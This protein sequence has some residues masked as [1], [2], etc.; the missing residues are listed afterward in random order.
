MVLA[1]LDDFC[2]KSIISSMLKFLG[3]SLIKS[4]QPWLSSLFLPSNPKPI[5]NEHA[6]LTPF[7][8]WVP[9]SAF[10]ALFCT[11]GGWSW[12]LHDLNSLVIGFLVGWGPWSMFLARH[13][14]AERV[15]GEGAPPVP[16]L[17]LL[18]GR[19]RVPCAWVPTWWLSMKCSYLENALAACFFPLAVQPYGDKRF[20]LF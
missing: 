4:K 13:P 8:S 20:F 15:R 10:S 17:A 3:N 14:R 6:C 18:A 9:P 2:L 11:S 5:Q 12:A 7:V 16:A 19:S 1:T